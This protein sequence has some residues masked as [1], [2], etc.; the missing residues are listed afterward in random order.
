MSAKKKKG[1]K[2]RVAF[3]KNRQKR[4]RQQNLTQRTMEDIDAASDL[5]CCERLN[6]KGA[7]SRHRTVM[8]E[9]HDETGAAQHVVDENCIAGRVLMAIGSNNCRVQTETG[10]LIQ[11]TVRRVVRTMARSA[12]NAV[13]AGDRVVITQADE[14]T[15]VIERVEPRTSALT[16]GSRQEAHLIVANV[17]QAV[18]VVS[19]RDPELKPGLIDRFLC[20][21]E[22]G[23]IRAMICINKL[24]L[25]DAVALQPLIGQYTQLGYEVILT[26]ALQGTGIA[27]LKELLKGKESVFTGHSG[28][29]KSSLLNAVQPGLGQR[30]SAVSTD[31]NK[32]R[33]TTRVT[34]LIKLEGGG[35]I[36]DT[37]GIR[38]LKLWDVLP[39]EV[40]GM[41]VEFRAFV[42]HCRYPNCSHTHENDCA[43]KGAVTR[44]E[45][46]PLR[47]RNYQRIFAG[48]DDLGTDSFR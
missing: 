14:S 13:V 26:D 12:R 42:A 45:I 46:S 8:V 43:V 19:T 15:G 40:E 48:D 2:V 33:H 10:E 20:S 23:G 31:T 6:G 36:V 28:V 30:T 17:D 9:E 41:F 39:E 22:M 25:G 47:F 1:K 4:V 38:Q 24:D 29:G 27:Q 3:K 11:C 21:T 18:I 16:R 32:G 7:T 5:E 35:W 34:E 37:P 44:G